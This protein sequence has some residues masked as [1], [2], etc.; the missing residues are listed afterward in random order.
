MGSSGSRLTAA[1]YAKQVVK[2]SSNGT[3]KS[4][5][6]A[7]AQ[8]DVN[9]SFHA[10]KEARQVNPFKRKPQQSSSSTSDHEPANKRPRGIFQTNPFA[11]NQRRTQDHVTTT[12]T[13]QSST[14]VSR[15]LET[16]TPNPQPCDED[17]AMVSNDHPLEGIEG[18]DRDDDYHLL[19]D[20]E[21]SE[22]HDDQQPPTYK[23]DIPANSGRRAQ[24]IELH[25]SPSQPGPSR[26][27]GKQ[28][29]G[30][31]FGYQVPKPVPGKGHRR[32]PA[33]HFTDDDDD[34]GELLMDII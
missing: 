28:R 16:H 30:D 33:T 31:D 14:P 2:V 24:R 18:A 6:G 21:G 29:A 19:E 22:G 1:P 34:A 4:D 27:K 25:A 23:W 11:V 32:L 15:G 20:N 7:G 13:E 17:Q 9:S 8:R 26:S 12:T 3:V 5:N 10:E